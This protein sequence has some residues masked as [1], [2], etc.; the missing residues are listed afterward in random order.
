[1]MRQ[2]FLDYPDDC[3]WLRDTH[4]RG[5]DPPEFGSFILYGNEDCPDKAELYTSKIPTIFDTPIATYVA[6]EETG[7]LESIR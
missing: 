4:L 3:A 5:L 1:M 7:E 6:N 2:Q